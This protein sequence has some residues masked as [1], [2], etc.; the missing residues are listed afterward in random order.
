MCNRYG[1]TSPG[2][3]GTDAEERG[4]RS[5]GIVRHLWLPVIVGLLV[6]GAAF[7]FASR[8]EPSFETCASLKV[9]SGP[10]DQAILGLPGSDKTIVNFIGETTREIEQERIA[11]RAVRDLDERPHDNA[12][13]LLEAYSARPDLNSGLIAICAKATTARNA[14]RIANATS[15]AYVA[16]NSEDQVRNLRTARRELRRVQASR[17]GQIREEVENS[18]AGDAARNEFG[19]TP[20]EAYQEQAEGQLERLLLAERFNAESVSLTKPADLTTAAAGIPASAIAM[21]AFLLSATL[22][23][24]LVALRVATDKRIRSRWDL[25]DAADAPILAS[26]RRVRLLRRRR[27]L[28]DL[29]RRQAEPFRLLLARLS[30]EQRTEHVQTIAFAPV[31]DDETAGGVVWYL[32]A[33]AADAGARVLVLEAN[34]RQ[35]LPADAIADG[36]PRRDIGDLVAGLAGLDDVITHATADERQAVDI[37]A[38]TDLGGSAS[39]Q[40]AVLAV[41]AQAASAYDLV[42]IHAEP[43]VS[44]DGLAVF[45]QAEAAVLVCRAD[46]ARDA[47]VR[48]AEQELART[49]TPLAGFVAVGFAR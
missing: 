34:A 30:N 18:G 5:I 39:L 1:V 46:H 43:V 6:G 16:L 24:A 2:N 15:R 45:R 35:P 41:L 17:I 20:E 27:R 22:T 40:R 44:A 8:G 49:G 4:P 37:V 14:Q 42:V 13:D 33:T 7:A 10:V 31:A 11:E 25:E 26:I 3:G 48:A 12:K 28:D 32:A 21:L 23:G 38:L 9:N 47:D 29:K 36:A 19:Q